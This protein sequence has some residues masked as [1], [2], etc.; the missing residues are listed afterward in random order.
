MD[1]RFTEITA[2]AQGASQVGPVRAPIRADDGLPGP[3]P[4]TRPLVPPVHHPE[5]P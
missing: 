5:V 1:L 3:R 2:E 4:S